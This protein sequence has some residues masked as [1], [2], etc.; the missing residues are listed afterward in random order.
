VVASTRERVYG[1]HVFLLE[2]EPGVYPIRWET[3][4]GIR[5]YMLALPTVVWLVWL[6][7]V[8]HVVAMSMYHRY[9]ALPHEHPFR[10]DVLAPALPNAY[11]DRSICIWRSTV[12]REA[13]HAALT[14]RTAEENARLAAEKQFY[15]VHNS[16][17]SSWFRAAGR[18]DP[19]LRSPEAWESA[20]RAD[21]GFVLRDVPWER[22]GRWTAAE[23]RRALVDPCSTWR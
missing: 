17:L 20:S 19:R 8:R 16:E 21:P 11:Q 7:D 14:D 12:D 6:A 13:F 2:N 23:A 4:H 10:A 5:T 1:G 9:Q 18:L 15:A 22:N 3:T